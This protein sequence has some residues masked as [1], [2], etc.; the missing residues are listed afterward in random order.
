MRKSL[1]QWVLILVLMGFASTGRAQWLTQSFNLKTGW[2]AVFLHVD[3]THRTLDELVGP[4]APVLTP[5][6]QVW[7]WTPNESMAQ[8]VESPQQPVESGSQWV[9]WRRSDG[10]LSE[11]SR[12]TAN[13]AYLVYVTEDYVWELKGKP[14]IPAYRWAT[15]G[16]NFVG[17]PTVAVDPPGFEDFL[18]EAPMMQLAEIFRYIGGEFG[19]SNPGRLFALRTTPVRRGEAYWMRSTQGYNQ[20]FGPFEVVATGGRSID[21]GDSLSTMGFRLRNWTSEPLTVSMRLRSSEAPPSGEQAIVDVPPLLVRGALNPIDT[22]YAFNEL[23]ADTTNTWTLAPYGQ[24]GSEAEVVLGLDRASIE[25]DVGDLLAGILEL[26]DS[27]GHSRVDV[28]VTAG[29]ASK[30]GL[31]VGGAA[32]TE[33]SQYLKSYLRDLNNQLVVQEDGSYFVSQVVTNLTPVPTAFPLRL[34]VHN[35]DTGPATLL[36][37]VYF[38]FDAGTNA[39]VTTSQTGLD[40]RFLSEARRISASHLPWSESNPGWDFSGPLGR[41]GIVQA[42]VTT[43]YEDQASNP[44]LHTYHPDHD[45]LDPRFQNQLPQGSESYRIEREVTLQFL[46]PENDFVSRVSAGTKLTG[47]YLETIRVLG[48]AQAGN[49]FD[50][51]RFDVRGAFSLQRV[52]E[53]PTLTRVP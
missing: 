39:V 10:G 46:P 7:R 16:L 34:I 22:I 8:F 52:A 6:E 12:L 53:V 5:I 1:Q 50:T 36:Q 33:V 9:S 30:A 43:P 42:V 2:N 24:P 20:Y 27:L 51:R 47:V 18:A 11:L 3:A 14:V 29:T 17:F 26:T 21:F 23:T 44:F 28:S 13:F 31:W 40:A 38:G 4:A 35:P 37:R 15:S 25:A 19:P 49:Q 48:L 32:I 41:E 45:N